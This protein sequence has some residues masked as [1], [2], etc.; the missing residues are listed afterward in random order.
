MI[1]PFA[2]QLPAAGQW[3]TPHRLHNHEFMIRWPGGRGRM[4][5]RTGPQGKTP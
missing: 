2:D 3:P 4:R 1:S 5:N